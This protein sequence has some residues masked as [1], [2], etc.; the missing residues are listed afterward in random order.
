MKRWMLMPALLVVFAVAT[1][2]FSQDLIWDIGLTATP[3]LG[4]EATAEASAEEFEL[5][6]GA[7]LGLRFLFIFYGSVDYWLVPPRKI[8]QMTSNYERDDVTGLET[9]TPGLYLPGIIQLY[10]AGIMLSLGP[11]QLGAEAGINELYVYNEA[12]LPDPPD[13]SVGANLMGTAGLRFGRLGATLRTIVLF[14][15]I[16]DALLT[17]GAAFD[18]TNEFQA[19]AQEYLLNNI[20]PSVGVTLYLGGN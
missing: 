8:E 7:H 15:S 9:R 17:L 3:L 18:S 1:P 5:M 16:E 14:P 12:E 20:I 19:D 6:S 4:E 13:S 11:I 10:D 2:V